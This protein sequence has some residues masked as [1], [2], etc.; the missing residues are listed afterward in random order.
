MSNGKN[1]NPV[2]LEEKIERNSDLVKEAA[3]RTSQALDSVQFRC[4][5]KKEKELST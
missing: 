4:N 2:E 5:F 1:V 3:R